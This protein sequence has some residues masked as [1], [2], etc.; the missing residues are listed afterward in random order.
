MRA[1]GHAEVMYE[2]CNPV[3]HSLL[4]CSALIVVLQRGGRFFTLCLGLFVTWRPDVRGQPFTGAPSL[5]LLHSLP[6]S[7]CMECCHVLTST[8]YSSCVAKI[9]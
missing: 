7:K 6:A 1:Y 5:C 4:C 3:L 9:R 8:G 2:D